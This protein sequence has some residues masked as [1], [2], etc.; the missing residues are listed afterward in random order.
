MNVYSLLLGRLEEGL[1]VDTESLLSVL[2]GLGLQLLV[3]P[4]SDTD[5]V[6]HTF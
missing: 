4:S 3:L 5:A 2:T 1:A 6:L